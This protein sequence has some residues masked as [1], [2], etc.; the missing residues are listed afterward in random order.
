[1]DARRADPVFFE[2]DLGRAPPDHPWGQGLSQV[3]FIRRRTAVTNLL[4]SPRSVEPNIAAD[5]NPQELNLLTESF[6]SL[7][8]FTS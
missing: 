7:P 6:T 4:E 8:E 1:V 5:I 2:N 3:P